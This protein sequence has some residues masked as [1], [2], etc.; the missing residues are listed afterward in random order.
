MSQKIGVH[1]VKIERP[2]YLSFSGVVAGPKEG[3]GPLS[4]DYDLI[5]EDLESGEKSFEKA[6]RLMMDE[7]CSIALSKGNF[8]IR[9]IDYFMAGDLLNQ[10][11]IAGFTG[12]NYPLPFLGIYGACANLTQGIGLGSIII[13]GG[14]VKRC[15]WQPPATTAA[16]SG[17]TAI[18]RSTAFRN[19]GGPSGP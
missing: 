15:W 14:L 1:T 10:I 9:D 2:V 4:A 17:S 6:E 13:G 5:K 7:A 19:R 12:L 18:P 16:R 3:R 8:G 11:T